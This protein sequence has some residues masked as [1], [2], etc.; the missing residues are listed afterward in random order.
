MLIFKEGG[1]G[2]TNRIKG[3]TFEIGKGLTTHVTAPIEAMGAASL[4]AFFYR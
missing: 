3:I 1:D 4:S 2:A